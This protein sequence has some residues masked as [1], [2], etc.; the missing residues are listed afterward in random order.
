MLMKLIPDSL[1]F[2]LVSLLNRDIQKHGMSESEQ[3]EYWTKVR[4]HNG[5]RFM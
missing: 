2:S 1:L 4:T 3:F 5:P